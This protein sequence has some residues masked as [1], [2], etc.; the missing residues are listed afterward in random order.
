MMTAHRASTKDDKRYGAEAQGITQRVPTGI[1]ELDAAFSGGFPMGSAILVNGGP[2][3]GKTILGMTYLWS[4]ATMY[5]EKG[6]YVSFAESK[7]TMYENMAGLG[8]DLRRLEEGG[9]FCFEEMFAAKGGFMGELLSKA[10]DTIGA[11]G[12]KRAVIDSISAV[13]QA[14]PDEYEGRQVFH[15]VIEKLI[16]NLG[17]TTLVISE[18]SEESAGSAPF[19]E[20]VADGILELKRGTPRIMEVRKMRGTKLV[21][22]RLPFTIDGGLRAL[23]TRIIRPEHPTKW[24]P[25]PARDSV[26]STG[27]PDLDRVL[28]GGFPRGAYAVLEVDTDV[29]LDEL[30]L[31][32]HG[33]TMNFL[34]QGLGVLFVPVG[35]ADANEIVGHIG[36]YLRPEDLHLLRVA[37]ELKVE[38]MSTKEVTI[39]SYVVLMK[40]GRNNIDVDTY[41]LYDT[42]AELKRLSDN[43]PVLR[44][45]GY[46]TM[47]SKYAEVPDKLYNEIGFAIMRTRAAG[48]LTIGIA[49]PTLSMLPK[50]LDMVDWHLKLW[51]VDGTLVFE[52]VKPTT[53]PLAVQCDCSEGYPRA[54][55]V[56]LT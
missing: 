10:M 1:K 46:D 28:G 37:E 38:Q 49:R 48:D 43:K 34:S 2:G 45:M 19:E 18:R 13:A 31:F 6:L 29:S 56:E 4:G 25:I 35:G 50:V 27:C 47:E 26:I 32:T 8:M 55:L 14:Y 3:S 15:T 24:K 20:F 11:H 52:G 42:L 30:R 16:R 54:R 7:K 51:K 40:G 22:R 33:M 23:E 12:I 41:A 17:C 39:P 21:K 9:M 44:I 36:P 5:H 53:R